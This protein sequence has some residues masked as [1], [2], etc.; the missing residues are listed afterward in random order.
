MEHGKDQFLEVKV[1]HTADGPEKKFKDSLLQLY[2]AT[3]SL[4]QGPE[5]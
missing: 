3:R 2:I 5:R 4:R 1:G